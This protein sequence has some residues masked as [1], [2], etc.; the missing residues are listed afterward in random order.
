M[1]DTF[2]VLVREAEQ[3]GDADKLN[4]DD[5]HAIREERETLYLSDVGIY[6]QS[7]QK[8]L[9]PNRRAN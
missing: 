4:A 8:H 9:E 7:L 1:V 5:C 3:D 2:V 6:D